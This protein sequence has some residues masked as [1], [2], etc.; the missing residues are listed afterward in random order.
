MD[1]QPARFNRR[2]SR[3]RDPTQYGKPQNFSH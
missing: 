3:R 1:A 2:A